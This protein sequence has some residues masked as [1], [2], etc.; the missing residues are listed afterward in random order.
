MTNDKRQNHLQLRHSLGL[1]PM[2][3]YA[4]TVHLCLDILTDLTYN[5]NTGGGVISDQC[6]AKGLLIPNSE[7]LSDRLFVPSSLVL[8]SFAV[9]VV[10]VLGLIL[11]Q[12]EIWQIDEFVA[13]WFSALELG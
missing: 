2:F 6:V 3:P 13:F 11:R 4:I 8:V 7:F 12:T 5:K 9:V 10:A 1:T